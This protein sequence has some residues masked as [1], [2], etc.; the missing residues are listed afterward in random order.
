[1][2]ILDSAR[3]V[4][5]MEG[6]G[7]LSYDLVADLIG[8]PVASVQGHFPRKAELCAAVAASYRDDFAACLEQLQSSGS[9]SMEILERYARLLR[10]PLVEQNRTSLCGLR[11]GEAARLPPEVLQEIGRFIDLNLAWLAGVLE[12]GRDRGELGLEDSP[13]AEANL[14]LATLEGAIV[15]VRSTAR[16]DAFDDSVATLLQRYRAA[17]SPSQAA[18]RPFKGSAR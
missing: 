14:L 12:R 15:L 4:V 5:K 2:R 10:K 8:I 13:A 1:M 18:G 17:C 6:Y 7:D 9:D 11:S 16:Y 3:A